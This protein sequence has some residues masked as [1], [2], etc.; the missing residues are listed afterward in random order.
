MI[1]EKSKQKHRLEIMA[2]WK[3]F[4]LKE[5]NARYW[6]VDTHHKPILGK[7]SGVSATEI[8]EFLKTQRPA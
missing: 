1:G 7:E 8:E 4:D 2:A 3:G 5:K 6:L